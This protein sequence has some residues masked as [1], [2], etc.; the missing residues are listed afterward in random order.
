MGKTKG[1]DLHGEHFCFFERRIALDCH[2]AIACDLLC[3]S[4]GQEKGS[5][6]TDRKK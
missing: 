1:D 3:E 5:G 2:G 6:K 4:D